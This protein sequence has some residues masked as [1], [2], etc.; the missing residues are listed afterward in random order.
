MRIAPMRSLALLALERPLRALSIGLSNI[1]GEGPLRNPGS[2]VL[3]PPPMG[4][5]APALGPMGLP[6]LLRREAAMR[7]EVEVG[8]K[9]A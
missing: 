6:L 8:L 4:L 1:L 7:W 5:L 2:S 9:E 3:L